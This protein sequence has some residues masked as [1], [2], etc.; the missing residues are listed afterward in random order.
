MLDRHYHMIG[1]AG[2]VVAGLIFIVIGLRDGD[3][4]TVAGAA[5]W[6]LACFVWLI[7]DLRRRR[8]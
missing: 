5:I 6:T 7:P 3:L 2:F 4:L 1:L 8:R